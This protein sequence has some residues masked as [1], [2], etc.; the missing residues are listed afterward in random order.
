MTDL[1]MDAL[2]QLW[3]CKVD[4]DRQQVWSFGNTL[5]RVNL[6]SLWR[7]LRASVTEL[8]DCDGDKPIVWMHK[9]TQRHR[10]RAGMLLKE[11]LPLAFN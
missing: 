3:T 6:K 2:A 8:T 1:S 5:L 11:K 4:V 10:Y 9:V 7:L